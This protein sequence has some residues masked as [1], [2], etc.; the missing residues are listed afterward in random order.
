MG[1][2]M[3]MVERVNLAEVDEG[4]SIQLTG[5]VNG[6]PVTLGVDVFKKTDEHLFAIGMAIQ[7]TDG[8]QPTV[9]MELSERYFRL[10]LAGIIE[11]GDL[12][13]DSVAAPLGVAGEIDGLPDEAWRPLG[14][15]CVALELFHLVTE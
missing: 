6:K 5:T 14:V 2:Q 8:E 13:I 10:P 9:D 11:P 4:N 15:G 1:Y 7:Q 3:D 12:T